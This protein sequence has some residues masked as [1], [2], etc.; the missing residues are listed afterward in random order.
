MGAGAVPRHGLRGPQAGITNA[1][2]LYD[3]LVKR[4]PVSRQDRRTALELASI[5][6]AMSHSGVL[7][8][9]H[10]IN[11]WWL[12]ATR[13]Q[14][15]TNRMARCCIF[16]VQEF[17]TSMMKEL[18]PCDDKDKRADLGPRTRAA[19]CRLRESKRTPRWHLFRLMSLRRPAGSA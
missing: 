4:H 10:P 17:F 1:K 12:M 9:G 16:F 7:S 6:D 2:S 3:A 5:V 18:S 8:G 13:R 15:W 19:T 11:E 14:T